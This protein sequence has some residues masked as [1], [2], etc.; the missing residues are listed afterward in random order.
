MK[1]KT[2]FMKR[3]SWILLFTVITM[4]SCNNDD[5]GVSLYP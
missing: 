4:V 5:G 2:N 3:A 1:K